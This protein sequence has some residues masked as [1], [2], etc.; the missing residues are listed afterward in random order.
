MTDTGEIVASQATVY[1]GGRRRWLT[2]RA[3]CRAEAWIEIVNEY[4]LDRDEPR[5][6]EVRAEV[7]RRAKQKEAAFKEKHRHD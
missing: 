6:D 3:A 5:D 4:A 1:H 2:L 7:N